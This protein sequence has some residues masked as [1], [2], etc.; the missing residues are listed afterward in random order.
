ML[1]SSSS[2]PYRDDVLVDD[3]TF[4]TIGNRIMDAKYVGVP[5]VLALGKS[6]HED[7]IEIVINNG[8]VVKVLGKEKMY[9]HSR[10]LAIVLK[11]LHNDYLYKRREKGLE[12]YFKK[13]E[14]L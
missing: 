9:C 5:Y 1:E 8:R 6:I 2:A 3:R 13:F 12:S 4:L 11:Q 7:Q 14:S 10:E